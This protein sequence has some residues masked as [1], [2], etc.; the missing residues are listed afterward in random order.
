MGR[1]EQRL[2]RLEELFESEMHEVESEV[3]RRVLAR[4]S[5]VELGVLAQVFEVMQA[6]PEVPHYRLYHLLTSLQQ[7]MLR[8]Y[9]R[10]T[11]EVK[12]E[13]ERAL[14]PLQSG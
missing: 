2:S 13:L 4:C 1:L 10:Y 8:E 14:K 9:N 3:F 11:R 6:N 5:N 12:M 7:E